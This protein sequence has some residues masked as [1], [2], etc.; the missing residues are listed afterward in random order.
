M[1]TEVMLASEKLEDLNRLPLGDS[2]L[3][4][5]PAGFD[6]TKDTAR[7]FDEIQIRRTTQDP[8]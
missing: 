3:A 7:F 6:L 2:N 1:G 8:R 5:G 4:P